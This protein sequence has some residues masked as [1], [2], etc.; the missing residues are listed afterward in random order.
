[1][2]KHTSPYLKA[3]TAEQAQFSSGTH[4]IR[5]ELKSNMALQVDTAGPDQSGGCV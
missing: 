4:Y 1:M 2:E 3:H 5:P